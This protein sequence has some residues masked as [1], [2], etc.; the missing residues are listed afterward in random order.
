ME[1]WFIPYQTADLPPVQ[2][3]LILAPHPDDEIFGCGGAAALLQ[4]RGVAIDVIVVTDGAG[5]ATDEQRQVITQ[6]RRAETNA[7]LAVLGIQ[8]AQFWGIADR[9][10][11]YDSTWV[12][13]IHAHLKEVDLVFAPSLS[14]VH[15]DHAATGRAVLE[16]VQSLVNRGEPAP[17]ILFYEVG[18]PLQP[19]FLLDITT[20]W[21]Q[22]ERAM[23]CFESQQSTQNYARHIEGLNTFR[24]YTLGP[25]ITHAEAYRWVASSDVDA[26]AQALQDRTLGRAPDFLSQV[27][28]DFE[29]MQTHWLGQR[30]AWDKEIQRLIDEKK[31][32]VLAEVAAW[33][34]KLDRLTQQSQQESLRHQDKLQE[35]NSVIHD[36]TASLNAS[37]AIHQNMLNSRSWRW[38][39]PLRWLSNLLRSSNQD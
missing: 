39:Q 15:P 19:N 6:T 28:A 27:E 30:A 8:P 21:T 18:A 3:V 5:F 35:L 1:N 25:Q 34:Q 37:L 10:L 7:A 26:Q 12:H 16:S 33:S 20:V 29:K 17:D 2:S 24:T 31:A 23:Q 4:Q 22:K 36:L 14:E 9:S 13:R 11:V 38:T 32:E